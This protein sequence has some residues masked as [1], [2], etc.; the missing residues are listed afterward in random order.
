MVD[1]G[2]VRVVA[3]LKT[4]KQRQVYIVQ[5]KDNKHEER[6]GSA[7]CTCYFGRVLCDC[8]LPRDT[9]DGTGPVR[10]EDMFFLEVLNPS[11]PSMLDGDL[12]AI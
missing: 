4:T 11:T 9:L 7:V 5:S 6:E 3:G 8:H 1:N 12:R 10:H 2:N